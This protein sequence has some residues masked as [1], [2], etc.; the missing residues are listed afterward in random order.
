MKIVSDT[1][2]IIDH[3]RNIPRATSLLEEIENGSFEGYISTIT[4]LELMAAP[5]MT[6]QRFE[7]I[8]E[9]I[10]MFEHVPVDE[11][12]ATAAGR[13]LAKYRASH[14]LQPMDAIIAATASVNEAV[15]FTLNTKHFKFIEGLVI[16]N[17]YLVDE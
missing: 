12:I 17:P 6:E 8:K 11:R 2:I 1:N 10:E 9:L 14:G 15:L 7:T 13:Y 16:I 4:I 5:R 3:L